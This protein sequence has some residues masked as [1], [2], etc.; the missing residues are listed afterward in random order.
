MIL[1]VPAQL[2]AYLVSRLGAEGNHLAVLLLQAA[3]GQQALLVV[4]MRLAGERIDLFV[5]RLDGLPVALAGRL[6]HAH[7][8]RQGAL[9]WTYLA[10][11]LGAHRATAARP[12]R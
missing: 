2:Q 8:Q 4:G 1:S 5:Q 7:A 12:A 3:Q 6:E 9:Q 11:W 10:R